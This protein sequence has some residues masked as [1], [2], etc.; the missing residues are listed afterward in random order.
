MIKLMVIL[1]FI[2]SP[3]HSAEPKITFDDEP[4][5]SGA[6]NNKGLI[7]KEVFK[8]KAKSDVCRDG[9]VQKKNFKKVYPNSPHP[10]TLIDKS[11][12]EYITKDLRMWCQFD[13]CN[14]LSNKYGYEISHQKFDYTEKIDE[15]WFDSGFDDK[16]H[17]Y[18]KRDTLIMHVDNDQSNTDYYYRCEATS[19]REKIYKPFNDEIQKYKNKNKI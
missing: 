2:I 14:L 1:L 7:C 16:I 17:T 10:L 5:Y 19:S 18:I 13:S 11:P 4:K 15:I 9:V 6:L 8:C 12:K 3:A